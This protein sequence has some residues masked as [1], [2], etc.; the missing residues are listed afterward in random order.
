MPNS[1]TKSVRKKHL[2]HVK[3]AKQKAKELRAQK[4]K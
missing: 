1:K 4:G 3:R 2:K